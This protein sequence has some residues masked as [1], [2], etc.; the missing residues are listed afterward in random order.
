M[1]NSTSSVFRQLISDL[2]ATGVFGL[3]TF[4]NVERP[5]TILDSVGVAPVALVVPES[6]RDSE[7]DDPSRIVRTVDYVVLLTTRGDNGLDRFEE[8]DRLACQIFQVV[9]GSSFGDRCVPSLSILD[10]QQVQR[11]PEGGSTIK[12]K[13]SFSFVLDLATMS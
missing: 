4:D 11:A 6:S 9:Q 2:E 1:D 12:L 5:E 13:G 8:L 10:R 7:T 3:V